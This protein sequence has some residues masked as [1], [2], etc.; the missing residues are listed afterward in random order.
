MATRKVQKLIYNTVI[1]CLLA[2]ALI[3]VCSRF[4]HPGVE[5]TDNAQV[6][7][8]IT[9]VNTRVQG[10]IKQICFEEYQP[11]HKG[12]TLVIIEDA[13]FKLRLAQAEADLP[14]FSLPPE[15]NPAHPDGQSRRCT[16]RGRPPLPVPQAP[17]AYR[18]VSPYTAAE[19]GVPCRPA[20]LLPVPV[21]GHNTSSLPRYHA[22]Q[23]AEPPNK[24]LLFLS[25]SLRFKL[26]AGAVTGV[27]ANSPIFVMLGLYP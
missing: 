3:Y 18:H 1:I 17:P 26:F 9:P 23:P 19:Y 5:Y 24:S 25:S 6:K 21:H 4:V 15:A 22:D 8:H 16:A 12:D 10:F 13:E 7:Q 2:V 27:P 20:S 14:R 11:I